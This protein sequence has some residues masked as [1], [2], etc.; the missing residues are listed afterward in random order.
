[1]FFEEYINFTNLCYIRR[2]G[3]IPVL[4]FGIHIHSQPSE[5]GLNITFKGTLTREILPLVF[6]TQTP[7]PTP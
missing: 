1:M 3:F 7:P 5:L 4:S 2:C 6:F